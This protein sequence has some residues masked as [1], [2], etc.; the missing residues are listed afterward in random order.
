MFDQKKADICVLD[1]CVARVETKKEGE[2][3]DM[4]G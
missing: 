4:P 2:L 1:C 3:N